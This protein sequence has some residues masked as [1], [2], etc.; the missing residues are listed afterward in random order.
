MLY[1]RVALIAFASL[2]TPEVHVSRSSPILAISP[3]QER[4]VS[5][6]VSPPFYWMHVPKCGASLAYPLSHIPHICDL[7][8][9]K[10]DHASVEKL[11]NQC[12][13]AFAQ[14]PMDAG[15]MPRFSD[16]SGIGAIYSKYVKGH[17][18]TILR[19]PEQRII[20]G[21]NNDAHSW[22]EALYKRWPANLREYAEVVNGCAVKMMTRDIN[23]LHFGYN[24]D[25]C[26]DPQ[27]VTSKEASLAV[28]RLREGFIFVG[29]IEEW[30]LSIC[31]FRHMFGGD[32]LKSD[33]SSMPDPHGGVWDD[34]K[35][36]DKTN[37]KS[38]PKSKTNS[39]LYDTSQLGDFRDV[40]DGA[41]YEEAQRMFA[42]ARNRHSVTLASCQPCFS[43]AGH[44]TD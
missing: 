37:W 18:V 34:G 22:P 1:V 35:E 29:I 6:E 40:H 30:D 25:A 39:S 13:G 33:F 11:P 27:P 2:N 15:G 7:G 9:E 12:P 44:A 28:E 5:A 41:L 19:Q 38:I 21:W 23:G 32:C 10:L 8:K 20:S 31:L 17:G 14:P 36:L 24:G 26:G 4:V 43:Q 16:H 3:R 42:E